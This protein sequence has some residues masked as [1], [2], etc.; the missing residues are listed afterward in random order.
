[1]YFPLCSHSSLLNCF[2]YSDTVLLLQT[3]TTKLFHSSGKWYA[4]SQSFHIIFPRNE[5]NW[6]MQYQYCK[7]NNNTYYIYHFVVT[8]YFMMYL[9]FFQLKDA[10]FYIQWRSLVVEEMAKTL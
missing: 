2:S 7:K 3:I 6:S 1:M 5:V 4:S 8:L 10:L 9:I